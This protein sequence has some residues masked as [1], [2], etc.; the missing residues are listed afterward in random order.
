MFISFCVF[1]NCF[2]NLAVETIVAG[3]PVDFAASFTAYFSKFSY[4]IFS[5]VIKTCAVFIY[6]C[7]EDINLFCLYAFFKSV[8]FIFFPVFFYVE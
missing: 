2:Y 6:E 5:Y 7:Y 1:L 4:P 8:D 3:S